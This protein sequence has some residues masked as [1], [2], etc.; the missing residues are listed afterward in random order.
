LP[1]LIIVPQSTAA[2]LAPL[3]GELGLVDAGGAPWMVCRP[4]RQAHATTGV[5]VERVN[6]PDTLRGAVA[7][8]GEA[9]DVPLDVISGVT[10]PL[11]LADAALDIYAVRHDGR[12]VGTGLCTYGGSVAG[13]WAMA[14]SAQHQRKGA[15]R[16]ILEHAIDTAVARGATTLFLAASDAGKHLYESVGFRTVLESR[17]WLAGLNGAPAAH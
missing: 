17:V 2:A 7:L 4:T 14:T 8:V 6:D 3:A 13:I 15:G 16:A 9:F 11:A 1:G 12:V 5:T 10:P